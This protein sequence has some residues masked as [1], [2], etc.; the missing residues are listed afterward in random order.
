M[1]LPLEFQKGAPSF[2]QFVAEH[3]GLLYRV[4]WS[5]VLNDGDAEDLT[6]D[7]LARTL[8]RWHRIERTGQSP[9]AYARRVLVNLRIDRWRAQGRE[10]AAYAR[11]A[12]LAREVVED[13]SVQVGDRELLREL[14]GELTVRQRRVVVLRYAVGMS[15][16]AVAAELGM[17]EG[18]VRVVAMRALQVLRAHQVRMEEC[19]A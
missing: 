17:R 9:Y 6:Q 3:G 18:N 8:R 4:A 13:S 16:A 14:L 1:A 15:S 12:V 2:E 5:L 10:R 19:D 7:A 11:D